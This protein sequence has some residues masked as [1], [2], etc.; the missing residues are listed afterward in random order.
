MTDKLYKITLQGC[1]PCY[2]KSYVV[3][4]DPTSAYQMVRDYLDG[5]DI[6][7]TGGR[8]LKSV[9]LIA[10]NEDYPEC[11]HKLFIKGVGDDRV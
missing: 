3:A 5:E 8:E 9:E 10:E 1:H 2:N 11:E 4:E 7:Y 6:G